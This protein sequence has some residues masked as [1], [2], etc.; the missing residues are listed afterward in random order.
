[1]NNTPSNSK[2]ST[3]FELPG[4]ID[5]D[6]TKQHARRPDVRSS[7]LPD[8]LDLN[9]RALNRNIHLDDRENPFTSEKDQEILDPKKQDVE[10]VDPKRDFPDKEFPEQEKEDEVQTP[11]KIIPKE[12]EH[13]ITNDEGD[14]IKEPTR[15]V[16]DPYRP[17]H[18]NQENVPPMEEEFP[19]SDPKENIETNF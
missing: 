5:Q 15:E 17:G 11:E 6:S 3:P 8:D 2:L 16:D 7:L 13:F 14:I 19:K 18:G 12:V 4:T 10:I 1:M 9:H